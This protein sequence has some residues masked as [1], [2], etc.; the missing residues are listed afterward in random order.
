MPPRPSAGTIRF[1]PAAADAMSIETVIDN[2]YVTLW[3]L[4]E[5]KIVYHRMHRFV[6][7]ARFHELLLAGTAL[8]QR[9]GGCKWL[10]DD[11]RNP[12]LA[13][14]LHEW[15]R[16]HWFPQTVAAGWKYWAV[17]RP[18]AELGSWTTER[19]VAEYQRAGIEACFFTD[20]ESA[21]AWLRT[22]GS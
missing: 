21:L 22:V 17:V 6:P 4:P 11:L 14:T 20:P 9:H 1:P 19:V 16:T 15:A 12:V 10:S 8:M 3:Y 13:E 18:E 5:D 2:A 7:E